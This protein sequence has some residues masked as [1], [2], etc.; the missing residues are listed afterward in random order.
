MKMKVHL[1]SRPRFDVE[2][3]L[4]FLQE[5]G[6]E[7]HRTPGATEPEEIVEVSGRV[8]YMSYGEKQSTRT[9][10]E[11]ILNLIKQGHESVLEHVNWTFLLVGVSRA[12]THQLV[13]HRAGF[14]FSQ[15]SQQYH[16]ET[17]AVFVEPAHLQQ[18]PRALQA[19]RN[20]MEVSRE[21][22][23]VILD[24]LG[25]LAAAPGLELNE[26]EFKRAIRSAARSVLPNATETKIVVTANA[27][28]LRHF[29][30]VR[31]YI[32]GDVEMREVAAAIFKLVQA[33]APSLF[34][35][36]RLTLLPD[37]TPVLTQ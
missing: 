17:S 10:A 9:N 5:E 21:S 8:C 20:A 33:E 6:T 18:S 30:K 37:E 24:S 35:D 28:A 26:R 3:F 32:P 14:S 23:K 25:E 12:F 34:S 16:E 4:S 27:R 1:I 13:R 19:W 2:A 11:Y 29:F 31:G 7:W 22:Y 36:F 15:L